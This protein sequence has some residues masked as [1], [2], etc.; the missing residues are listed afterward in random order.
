MEW[1]LKTSHIYQ[2]VMYN[3]ISTPQKARA[4][5]TGR[6]KGKEIQI[7]SSKMEMIT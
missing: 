1:K 2:A 4:R 6:D 7:K 3:G 5:L